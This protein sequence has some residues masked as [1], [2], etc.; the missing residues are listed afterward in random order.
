MDIVK[1]ILTSTLSAAALFLIAKIVGHKQMSQLDL[2]DY[3]TGITIGSIAAELA[4]ELETPWKPLVAMV[5]YGGITVGLTLLTSKLPRT[6]KFING[7]P[8]IIMNGGKLYR[9]NMKQAKMDLSEFMMMCRQEGYFNLDDIQTAIFEYNG[10]LTVLPKA[11][12]RP[13]NPED[14]N[15]VPPPETIHTEVI[16][17]GRILDENLKR[18]GLDATWLNKQLASQGYSNAREVFLGV[19]DDNHQLT[20]FPDGSRR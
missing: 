11:T 8:T 18:M 15:L 4:T 5:V 2:F 1:V 6:R 13:A 16:M 10:R 9:Q 20:V 12:K 3:I 7:T 19:C 14:M 17:D